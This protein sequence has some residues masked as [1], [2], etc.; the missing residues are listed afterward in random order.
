MKNVEM[1]G[2]ISECHAVEYLGTLAT[3]LR[4]MHWNIRLSDLLLAIHC[5]AVEYLGTLATYVR[6]MHW[7][8][9]MLDLLLAIHSLGEGNEMLMIILTHTSLNK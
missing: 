4:K 7:N 5:R 2:N 3:Y 1:P 6:K 9:R 8:I